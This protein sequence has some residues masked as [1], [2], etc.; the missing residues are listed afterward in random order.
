MNR[1]KKAMRFIMPC[2]NLVF[3][4]SM[5]LRNELFNAVGLISWLLEGVR[6]P[7]FGN[8]TPPNYGN[9]VP[10]RSGRRH[11]QGDEFWRSTSADACENGKFFSRGPGG[12][13]ECL[14]IVFTR[15][16]PI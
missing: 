5:R 13:G 1:K 12:L 6:T 9:P 11:V 7:S 4:K 8:P 3:F 2:S 15:K 10:P 14:S 16:I